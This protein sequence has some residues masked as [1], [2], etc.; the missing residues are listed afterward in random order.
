LEHSKLKKHQDIQKQ[1]N[2]NQHLEQLTAEKAA[3]TIWEEFNSS[4]KINKNFMTPYSIS[5]MMNRAPN[6]KR[7]VDKLAYLL[8]KLEH[9]SE[10]MTPY[11][12]A[13][14]LT[15]ANNH[16]MTSKAFPE[17]T[18]VKGNGLRIN[19]NAYDTFDSLKDHLNTNPYFLNFLL[20]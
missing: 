8:G 4:A 12:K 9:D 11:A 16:L 19:I 10:N 1:H 2:I 5:Y 13:N 18:L 6:P 7:D 17:N 3:P 20:V 15:L 14:L